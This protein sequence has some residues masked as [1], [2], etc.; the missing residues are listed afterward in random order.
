M[1]PELRSSETLRNTPPPQ[2]QPCIRCGTPG[3]WAMLC[4][5]LPWKKG[6]NLYVSS[7]ERNTLQNQVTFAQPGQPGVLK[8][9]GCGKNGH[10]LQTCWH[11]NA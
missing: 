7:T 6:E 5:T 8:C 10:T 11:K 2:G 9:S 4:N 1:A 3:H